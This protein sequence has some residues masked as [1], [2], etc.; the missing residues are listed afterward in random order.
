MVNSSPTP[1]ASDIVGL[2]LLSTNARTKSPS[3]IVSP[4]EIDGAVED[5]VAVAPATK[6][7][8]ENAIIAL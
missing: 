8:A 2:E 7:S 4:C 3:A 6:V 1:L 5:P